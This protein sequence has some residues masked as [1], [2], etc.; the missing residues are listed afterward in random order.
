MDS[1]ILL[2]FASGIHEKIFTESTEGFC[3]VISCILLAVPIAIVPLIFCTLHLW[4]DA[5]VDCRFFFS[6]MQ[7]LHEALMRQD[8]LLAYI[9]S[10]AEAKFRVS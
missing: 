5:R 6:L 3:N 10:Q 7:A 9:D 8:D 1:S 4:N 2:L